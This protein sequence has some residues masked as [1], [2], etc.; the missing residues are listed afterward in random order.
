MSERFKKMAE[1]IKEIL[2]DKA[3][4]DI[5]KDVLK[6]KRKNLDD[7]VFEKVYKELYS[8]L[9]LLGDE[10]I[11]SEIFDEEVVSRFMDIVIKRVKNTTLQSSEIDFIDE[12]DTKILCNEKIIEGKDFLAKKYDLFIETFKSFIIKELISKIFT[13]SQSPG[14]KKFITNKP[15]LEILYFVTLYLYSLDKVDLLKKHKNLYEYVLFEHFIL[16]KRLTDNKIENDVAIIISILWILLHKEIDLNLNGNVDLRQDGYRE[17]TRFSIKALLSQI[18]SKVL[19]MEEEKIIYYL[20]KLVDLNLLYKFL[21]GLEKFEINEEIKE[22]FA[23]CTITVLE[24]INTQSAISDSHIEILTDFHKFFYSKAREK[25]ESLLK[26]LCDNNKYKPVFEKIILNNLLKED[27][28]ILWEESLLFLLRTSIGN[29]LLSTKTMRKEIIKF[30]QQRVQEIK[31]LFDEEEEHYIYLV[32]QELIKNYNENLNLTFT[33]FGTKLLKYI[34]DFVMSKTTT[35][36]WPI[37]EFVLSHL[38]NIFSS[39]DIE[40]FIHQ[41]LGLITEKFDSLNIQNVK[42]ILEKI[43]KYISRKILQEY[44]QKLGRKLI[45][46]EFPREGIRL[47]RKL[48]EIAKRFKDTINLR[49]NLKTYL[50]NHPEDEECHKLLNMLE[51]KS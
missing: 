21:D 29:N 25:Y 32:I 14:A 17:R 10:D 38:E 50:Q 20:T 13:L 24:N 49:G 5:F 44:L 12:Y 27:V 1:G 37:V 3:L 47:F 6:E 36:M 45:A 7:T 8:T 41:F 34:E 31:G 30:L 35:E 9:E 46:Q 48:L 15:L 42:Q 4:R 16:S 11:L 23:R 18:F 43:Q 2:R 51:K 22:K 28:E 39:K 33:G 40:N 26:A 19:R